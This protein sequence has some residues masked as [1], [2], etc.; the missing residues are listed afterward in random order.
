MRAVTTVAL[1][2]DGV[3]DLTVEWM[4]VKRD[5]VSAALMETDWAARMVARKVIV[6]V[7]QM[8]VVRGQWSVVM[9]AVSMVDDLAVMMV[10]SMVGVTVETTVE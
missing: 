1:T 5:D 2:D 9:R 4:A 7:W 6:S 3:V 8:A 10:L